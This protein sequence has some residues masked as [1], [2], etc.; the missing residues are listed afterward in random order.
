MG[1]RKS[2]DDLVKE[3]EAANPGQDVSALAAL[4]ARVARS[5]AWLAIT[6]GAMAVATVALAI[7]TLA[8]R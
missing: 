4:Q 8:T 5:T 1:Q 2:L 3:V 6:T 7:V